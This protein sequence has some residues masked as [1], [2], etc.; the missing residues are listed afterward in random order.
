MLKEGVMGRQVAQKS[1][2]VDA[3]DCPCDPELITSLGTSAQSNISLRS[4]TRWGWTSPLYTCLHS[5]LPYPWQTSVI[6]V[7]PVS[8]E[9]L[10]GSHYQLIRDG[11]WDDPIRDFLQLW[12]LGNFKKNKEGAYDR[13]TALILFTSALLGWWSFHEMLLKSQTRVTGERPP[14]AVTLVDVFTISQ[15]AWSGFHWHVALMANSEIT[16]TATLDIFLSLSQIIDRNNSL[17]K[18]AEWRVCV[19]KKQFSI[20]SGSCWGLSVWWTLGHTYEPDKSPVA[21]V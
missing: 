10:P 19:Q 7:D 4:R 5:P 1:R 8:L 20:Y 9:I 6:D 13:E 11:S 15:D 17:V 18:K 14:T 21:T 12:Y 16:S 3:S 2:D